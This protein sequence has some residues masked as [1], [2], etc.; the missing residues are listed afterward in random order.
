M[1]HL[2]VDLVITPDEYLRWYQGSAKSVLAK[3]RDGRKVS[4]P[5]QSLQPYVTHGGING[6]FAIHFDDNHKLV[7]VEKLQ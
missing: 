2:I 7:R 4:F 3:T 5:A 6:T 1:V